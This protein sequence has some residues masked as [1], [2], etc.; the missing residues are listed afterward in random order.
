VKGDRFF[1]YTDGVTEAFNPQKET[2]GSA[3]LHR[4]LSEEIGDTPESMIQSIRQDI[5]VFAQGAPSHDDLTCIA[6]YVGQTVLS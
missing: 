4:V 1:I 3:R 2:Y 5:R 6:I